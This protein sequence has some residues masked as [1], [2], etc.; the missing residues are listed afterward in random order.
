MTPR[1]RQILVFSALAATLLA[2]FLL[3]E[4]SPTSTPAARPDARPD[5]FQRA[6]SGAAPRSAA[7][8]EVFSSD[9]DDLF[10]PRN[11]RPAPPPPEVAAPVVPVPPPM[12]YVYTGRME[13]AG[14][15]VLFLSRQ[16]RVVLARV[17]DTLEGLY[18]VDR[19]TPWSV[20]FTYLPLKQK[21]SLNFAQ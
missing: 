19:I 13:Q 12:P 2:V 17:G 16:Q 6:A 5:A 18:H 15:T 14:Q 1:S 11:W 3:P 21:Q 20:D 9:T 8:R 10:A 4:E 7:V